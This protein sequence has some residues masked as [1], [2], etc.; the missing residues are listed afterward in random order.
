MQLTAVLPI[1]TTGSPWTAASNLS[2][3]TVCFGISA[4]VHVLAKIFAFRRQCPIK[5]LATNNMT[6]SQ[7]EESINLLA[8]ACFM[9][10]GSGCHPY[11]FSTPQQASHHDN[12]PLIVTTCPC[13]ALRATNGDTCYPQYYTHTHIIHIYAHTRKSLKAKVIQPQRFSACFHV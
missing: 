1:L 9:S 6:C 13:C 7:F 12:S 8:Q 10:V 5:L 4:E 3:H 2:L 11:I